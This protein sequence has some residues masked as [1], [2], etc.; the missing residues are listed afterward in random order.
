LPDAGAQNGSD[1][2]AGRPALPAAFL[3]PSDGFR[4]ASSISRWIF[5]P[6]FTVAS[7]FA[8]KRGCFRGYGIKNFFYLLP[9]N[10]RQAALVRQTEQPTRYQMTH[11]R[12]ARHA[13]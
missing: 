4:S 2:R 5:A 8:S 12:R 3:P 13:R 10:V 6:C 11:V 9:S 1:I 7:A